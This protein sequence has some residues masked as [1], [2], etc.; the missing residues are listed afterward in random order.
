MPEAPQSV[1][2]GLRNVREGLHLRWNPRA[3]VLRPGQYDASGDLLPPIYEPRWELWDKDPEGG[4]YKVMTLQG[5]DGSFRPPGEWLVELMRLMDPARYGGSVNRMLRAL[6]DEH[7]ASLQQVSE[8]DFDDLAEQVA[9][10]AIYE[11]TPKV[12]VLADV[13]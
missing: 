8:E 2:E 1:V 9:K 7:N 3:K 4:E 6:V 11:R 10:W 13:R 5:P 12:S